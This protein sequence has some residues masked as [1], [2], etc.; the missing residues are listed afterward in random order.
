MSSDQSPPLAAPPP[1]PPQA[2]VYRQQQDVLVRR[3][4]A[5]TRP[6]QVALATYLVIGTLVS[7]GLQLVLRDE[8]RR[9]ALAQ[10]VKSSQANP[11]V[12]L[13]PNQLADI[14][15][16]LGLVL[17]IV[18]SILYV[19]LAVLVLAKPRTWVFWVAGA[20]MT[21]QALGFIAALVNLFLPEPSIPRAGAAIG[22]ILGLAGAA[23]LAWMVAGLVKYGPW[24][25]EKVRAEG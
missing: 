22:S 21:L 25:Q 24:A 17:G 2:P 23:I 5:W 11:G 10:A 18:F 14:S 8:Y 13:D 3:P 1:G 7:L 6:M 15:V 20:V 12:V 19:V 16:T 4:T 9:L